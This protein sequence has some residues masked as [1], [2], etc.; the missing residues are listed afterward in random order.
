MFEWW[1]PRREATMSDFEPELRRA[2][3]TAATARE[4]REHAGAGM[5]DGV[6]G[7]L[8]RGVLQRK[9]ARRRAQHARPAASSEAR[10]EVRIEDARLELVLLIERLRA[11]FGDA[12]EHYLRL[13]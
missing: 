7:R 12:V 9:L 10:D 1:H 4:P 13:D 6:A 2:T 11:R 3:A 5:L 8:P